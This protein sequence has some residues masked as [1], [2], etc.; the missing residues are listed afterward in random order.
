VR[1]EGA[2]SITIAPAPAVSTSVV[3]AIASDGAH[4][5]ATVAGFNKVAL[6]DP[7]SAQIVATLTAGP[8]PGSVA[9]DGAHAWIAEYGQGSTILGDTITEIGVSGGARTARDGGA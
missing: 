4:V 3:G 5:W 6:I 7:A 8:G 2:R 9:A 1:A